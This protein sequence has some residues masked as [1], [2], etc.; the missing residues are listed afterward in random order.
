VIDVDVDRARNDGLAAQAEIG[1]EYIEQHQDDDDQQ[2]NGKD[3]AASATARFDY[4][5]M[6]AFDVVA[7]VAHWKLSLLWMLNWRNERT[8]T[9]GVPLGRCNEKGPISADEHAAAR[10][11]LQSRQAADSDERYGGYS[12]ASGTPTASGADLANAAASTEASH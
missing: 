7:I 6:F 12:S 2:D 1:S 11:L 5:R 8:I 4:G 9:D 10:R 3:S